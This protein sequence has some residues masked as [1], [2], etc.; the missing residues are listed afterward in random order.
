MKII[1]YTFRALWRIKNPV[2]H[3]R[4]SSKKRLIS[5]ENP[6]LFSQKAPSKIIDWALNTSLEYQNLPYTNVQEKA[7]THAKVKS[8][9]CKK[10]VVRLLQNH[11]KICLVKWLAQLF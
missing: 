2:K 5:P 11:A 6:E 7:N 1:I 8:K 3:L 10:G 4:W 9:F